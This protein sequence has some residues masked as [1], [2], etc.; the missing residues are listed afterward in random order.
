MK[1]G[2]LTSVPLGYTKRT[3]SLISIGILI[4]VTISVVFLARPRRFYLIRHGETIL[5]SQH[6][7][8]GEEGALSKKVSTKQIWLVTI[9]NVST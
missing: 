2:M 4:L 6:I 3:M 1:A 5:N 8:Q 9:S 7:R